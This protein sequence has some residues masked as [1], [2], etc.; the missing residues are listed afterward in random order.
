MPLQVSSASRQ[1][2][3]P[4]PPGMPGTGSDS[5]QPSPAAAHSS[6]ESPGPFHLIACYSRQTLG[7]T[8]TGH[9]SPLG[10]YHKGRDLVL[11]LDVARFKYAPHWVPLPLLYQAM[12]PADPATGRPRGLLIVQ[13]RGRAAGPRAFT[14]S[15]SS[16]KEE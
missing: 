1:E 11:I 16:P 3:A 8:G 4:G 5:S 12:Q 10:G 13:A 9:F 2:P 6:S 7:Q 15:V 14:L